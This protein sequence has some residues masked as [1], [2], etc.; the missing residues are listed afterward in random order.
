MDGEELKTEGGPVAQKVALTKNK[1]EP[2]DKGGL[3]LR[4]GKEDR[5][6]IST[7]FWTTTTTN[8]WT[9]IIL[10]Y[11]HTS[12]ASKVFSLAGLCNQRKELVS[13]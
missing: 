12:I 7:T 6:W 4:K 8:Y 2:K 1:T 11:W 13:W 9:V 10:T 3:Q 5:I